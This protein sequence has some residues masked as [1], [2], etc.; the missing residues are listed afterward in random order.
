[1][2]K[3][4]ISGL[5][6]GRKGTPRHERGGGG[7]WGG[8]EGGGGGGGGGGGFCG[9]EEETTEMTIL[10]KSGDLHRNFKVTIINVEWPSM[11]DTES[12]WAT[13]RGIPGRGGKLKEKKS[14][15]VGKLRTR[16]SEVS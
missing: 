16:G 3:T 11:K 2:K 15:G 4:A 9:E 14:G 6:R 5:H 13:S 1:M 7:F 10:L 8:G 12:H